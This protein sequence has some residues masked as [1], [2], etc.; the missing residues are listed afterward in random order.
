MIPYLPMYKD[1]DTFFTNWIC[2]LFPEYL[3]KVE[4]LL[5]EHKGPHLLGAKLT[6]ADFVC[7]QTFFLLSHNE[8][9]ENSDIMMA[10]M[11]GYP[12]TKAWVERMQVLCASTL[13][14]NKRPF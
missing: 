8:A 12:L 5:K 14:K 13:S 4:G 1:K 2:K 7:S 11:A 3:A 6:L 9:Y 10:C